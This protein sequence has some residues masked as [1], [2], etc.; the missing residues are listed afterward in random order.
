MK[1]DIK[2]YAGVLGTGFVAEMAPS[3]LKGALVTAL[4]DKTVK[5]ATEWVEKKVSL[6][7]TLSVKQQEGLKTLAQKAGRLNWLTGEWVIGAIRKDLPLLASLFLGWRK[8]HN[9][10]DRQ[11]IIIRQE[12]GR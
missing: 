8:A 9:W 6:W 5:E 4:K 2:E 3:I 12:V 11:V 7:D 10:L 1:L